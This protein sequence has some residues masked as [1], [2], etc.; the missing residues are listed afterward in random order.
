MSEPIEFILRM[1]DM[2]SGMFPKVGSTAQNTFRGVNNN[3]NQTQRNLNQLGKG[4]KIKVDTSELT[5]ANGMLGAIVGGNII[6]AGVGKIAGTVKDVVMDSIEAAMQYG[7]RAKSFEVLTGDPK[8]GRELTGEL[9]NLK[10]STIMGA[11]VYQNA[12]TLMGFGVGDWEVIKDLREIGD[13]AM[14]DQERMHALTLAF[15][16]TRASGKLMGQDLLQ[17]VNAG[18]NPLSIMSERWKDFGFKQKKSV[19]E[20]KDMMSEGTISAGMVAK[21]FEIATSKGGKFYQ[22]MDQIGLT[23]GGKKMRAEGN[24][25]ALKIDMGNAMMPV[26]TSFIDAASDVMHWVHISK[27][28]PETLIAEKME[29]NSLVDSI[30][31]LNEG[32]A[33]R[34][35]MIDMLKAKYPDLFSGIDK[36]IVKNEE[37]KEMLKGVNKEYDKRMNYASYQVAGDKAKKDAN[38]LLELAAKAKAEANYMRQHGGERS[39]V[40]SYWDRIKISNS[41]LSRANL[42]SDPDFYDAFAGEVGKKLPELFKEQSSNEAMTRNLDLQ[43]LLGEANALSGDPKR[44]HEM[45]GDKYGTN[46]GQ[47][48]KQM[49]EWNQLAKQTGG[50][51]TGVFRDHDWSLLDKLTHYHK[52]DPGNGND[53]L[54]DASSSITGGGQK[55]VIIYLNKSLIGEQVYHVG[56]MSEA[57][58]ISLRTEEEQLLRMLQSAAVAIS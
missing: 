35:R 11:S 40:L 53:P 32:N 19:G 38:E 48:N 14:G 4:V 1:K 37:L 3:I 34:G 18:F 50:K 42:K 58:E 20:L 6:T 2:M 41:S 33:V 21:A 43:K 17:Y 52:D 49:A 29:V 24:W 26:A 44:Q 55:K 46:L 16:Q 8:R 31:H 9:R 12:Q 45:W 30:T 56:T 27:T 36:E 7:M 54:T 47:F 15:A 57:K 23:A 13:I 25:A 5:K 39:G 10:Q 51:L 28:V 22:M